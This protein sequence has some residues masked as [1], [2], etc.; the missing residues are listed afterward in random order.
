MSDELSPT[1][2]LVPVLLKLE[3]MLPDTRCRG[4][5]APSLL[6][7]ILSA[8]V[9][10]DPLYTTVKTCDILGSGTMDDVKNAPA[11]PTHQCEP[12]TLKNS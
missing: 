10:P 6:N 7:F 4:T 9:A 2:N 5:S 8:V 3:L 11:A 12:D 1:K